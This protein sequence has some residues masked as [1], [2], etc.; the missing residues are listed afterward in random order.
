MPGTKWKTSLQN[1]KM[2]E[3]LRE[4][5]GMSKTAAARIS[6]AKTAGNKVVKTTKWKAAK[7]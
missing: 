7:K 5:R 3:A 2:Y 1:P 4:K 6:N